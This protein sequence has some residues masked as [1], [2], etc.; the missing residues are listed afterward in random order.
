MFRLFT[1]IASYRIRIATAE[2][3]GDKETVAAC[4]RI[5]Y[6]EFAMVK[7]LRTILAL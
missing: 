3:L 2:Y 1:E 6:E 4:K 5:L 7:W